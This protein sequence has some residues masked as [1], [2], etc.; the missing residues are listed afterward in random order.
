VVDG[1]HLGGQGAVLLAGQAEID[2]ADVA[3][4]EAQ[5]APLLRGQLRGEGVGLLPELLPGQQHDLR[6]WIGGEESSRSG[7]G[8]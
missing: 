3:D 7:A 8:P 1:R 6:P 5:A 2:V 4:E